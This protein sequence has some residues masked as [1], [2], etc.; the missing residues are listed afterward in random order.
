MPA[1][2]LKSGTATARARNSIERSRSCAI[3]AITSAV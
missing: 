2:P 3:S 1:A